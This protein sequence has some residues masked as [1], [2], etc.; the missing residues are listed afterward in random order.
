MCLPILLMAMAGCCKNGECSNFGEMPE[1][2]IS[3]LLND[4]KTK[5]TSAPHGWKAV[6]FST[7]T[8]S[9]DAGWGFFFQ[10]DAHGQVK[11][12]ADEM[13]ITAGIDS[14]TGYSMKALE[15]PS[16]IFDSY[17]YLSILSNPENGLRGKGFSS[18]I[19]YAFIGAASDTI[20]LQG[21]RNK[22][23]AILIKA[24]EEDAKTN[25]NQGMLNTLIRFK[26]YSN[27]ASVAKKTMKIAINQGDSLSCNYVDENSPKIIRNFTISY[28]DAADKVVEV[29]RTF[30]PM[31]NGIFLKTPIRYK[32]FVI[33]EIY[34]D[35]KKDKPFILWKGTR[36]DFIIS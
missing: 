32:D 34:F 25:Q 20:R 13:L 8:T 29:K 21:N 2:R 6:I 10:F 18:D 16:L 4:Y 12:Y 23:V 17:S 14:I 26:N 35:L 31:V 36:Y 28:K 11:S 9:Y 30:A 27:M 33:N 24:T 1:G 5:L 15:R 7:D 19:E 3:G 22:T